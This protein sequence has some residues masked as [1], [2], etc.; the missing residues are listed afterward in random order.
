MPA[1]RKE[2]CLGPTAF[3]MLRDRHVTELVELVGGDAFVVGD[4]IHVREEAGEERH[5]YLTG[6][7][8]WLRVTGKERLTKALPTGLV[9][10]TVELLDK[11]GD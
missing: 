2:Q 6:R 4:V 8:I 11:E 1:P 10:L 3:G 9:V 5:E 7:E